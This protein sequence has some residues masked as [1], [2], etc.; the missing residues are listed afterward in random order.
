MNRSFQHTILLFEENDRQLSGLQRKI[1]RL[2]GLVKEKHVK[3][4]A[5]ELQNELI[6]KQITGLQAMNM[7]MRADVNFL[8]KENSQAQLQMDDL[9]NQHEAKDKGN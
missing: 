4:K 8:A 5:A 1:Q 9:R 6:S 3:L 2:D 7:Q